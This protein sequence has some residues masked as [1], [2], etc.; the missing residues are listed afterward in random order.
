MHAVYL[1]YNAT[2]PL[3][4]E[5]ISRMNEVMAEPRNA[6]SVHR[7]G[8][9]ARKILEDARCSI[10]E[11]IS[12]FHREIIFTAS[13]TEANHWALNA[14][15]GRRVLAST[16]EHSSVLKALPP[17]GGG[18]GGGTIPV[19]SDGIVDLATLDRMLADTPN[20]LV[21]V[22]LANNETGVIQPVADI[23]ALCTKHEALFHC[24]AVQAP[25][26]I[27]LDAGLLGADLITL[28]S[29]K[30]GGPVGAAA[31]VVRGKLALQPLLRGGG[32]EGN[33]RAG[34]E[35]VAAI[36][37]FAQA[38]E[39]AQDLSPMKELRGWLDE[40]EADLSAGGAVVFGQKAPRL[41]NTSCLALP[42]KSQEVQ[43]M[44]FDLA[45]LAVSAGSACSSGRIEPSHVLMAMGI[46]PERAGSAVRVSGGWGTQK[47]DMDAF[48]KAWKNLAARDT[49]P[50][51]KP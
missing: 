7:Y 23:Q 12:V 27:P 24:D 38:M 3:R 20:A 10:G 17:W 32:Q 26:K 1:D 5:V 49:K 50:L 21:S 8:R 43:L 42:G 19:T 34:T 47:A 29:H 36:A 14:F 40:M 18:L 51:P 11:C 48:A 30:C 41:P 37:G 39:L 25:G 28:T 33:R 44:H 6:S 35:N 2:A 9:E 4:R 15:P 31:L 13:A 16:V 22:M 45:G 46:S